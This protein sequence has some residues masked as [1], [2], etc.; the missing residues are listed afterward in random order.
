LRKAEKSR[1]LQLISGCLS[2]EEED[3]LNIIVTKVLRCP[4]TMGDKTLS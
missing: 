1:R 2:S 3:N 4:V